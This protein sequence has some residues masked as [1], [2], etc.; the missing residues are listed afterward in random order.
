MSLSFRVGKIPV[1]IQPLFFVVSAA[2]GASAGGM[3]AVVAW[4]AIVFVSVML[5]EF[6]HGAAGL[7][8]GLEPSIELHAMG[9]TTSWSAQRRLSTAQRVTISLAGPFAGFAVAGAVWAAGRAYPP[10]AESGPYGALLYVNLRW[11]LANLV[12]MLPLDGGNVMTHLLNAAAPGRGQRAAHIVSIVIAGAL[13]L[14][15]VATQ[16]W[17]L[18]MLG[19]LFASSNWR[20][21]G[22]LAAREHDAP[23]R[24]ALNQAYAALDARDAERLLALARPIALGSRTAPVRAEA[25]QLLA[26]G[27]LLEGRVADADAAIAALPEGFAPHPS[28]LELRERH[29]RQA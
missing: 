2:L 13:L 17:W 11:G 3:P 29:P 26:F 9:G 22:D 25:L 19:A 5:H 1:R 20:A 6:G 8:F 24:E 4:V 7:A 15:S 21:L 16:N 28:L 27:F 10:F 12:P 18:V 14:F 23:M